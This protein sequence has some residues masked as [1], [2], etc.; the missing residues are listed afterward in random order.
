[1]VRYCVQPLGGL[2]I[3]VNN[4]GVPTRD[5]DWCGGSAV[6]VFENLVAVNLRGSLSPQS[7]P[8]R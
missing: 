7:R 6:S 4:A 5:G 3:L 1:M 8:R 2:D